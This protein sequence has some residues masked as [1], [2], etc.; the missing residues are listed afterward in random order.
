MLQNPVVRA[1]LDEGIQQA[2]SGEITRQ[3]RGHFT[4]L[5]ERLGA[6]ED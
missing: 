1:S 6:D 4:R 5:A 2:A 3:K